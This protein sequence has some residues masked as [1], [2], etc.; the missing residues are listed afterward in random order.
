MGCGSVAQPEELDWFEKLGEFCIEEKYDGI[1]AACIIDEN[2]N[3]EFWSRNDKKKTEGEVINLYKYKLPRLKNS[4]LIGELFAFS[5]AAKKSGNV[6]F[7]VFDIIKYKGQDVS[8]LNNP[9]RR[10][11]IESLKIYNGKFKLASRF[12]KDFKKTYEDIIKNGGEGIIIKKVV[13]KTPYRGNTHN[14]NWI[15]VKKEVRISY[16]VCG[17]NISDSDSWAG[18]IK[19]IKAGL[20]DRNGELKVVCNVGSMGHRERRWFSDHQKEAIGKVIEVKGYEIFRSGAVR[21]PS[22]IGIR[23]DIEPLQCNFEQIYRI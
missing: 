5:Q 9:E 14:F 11:I 21:H 22:L 18:D 17:F 23:D 12:Y 10:E 15:K 1:W 20:Y 19:S 7:I 4:I 2:G 8:Q 16:V 6:S 3:I 13:G